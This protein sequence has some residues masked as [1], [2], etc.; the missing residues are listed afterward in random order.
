MKAARFEA[1]G[2]VDVALGDIRSQLQELVVR[3]LSQELMGGLDLDALAELRVHAGPPDVLSLPQ[4]LEVQLFEP[5]VLD[6]FFAQTAAGFDSEV[7]D[8]AG[9][10][11]L[12]EDVDDAVGVDLEGDLDLHLA[13]RGR[14]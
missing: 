2:G 12:G 14:A 13:A 8:V 6:L 11:V 10:L 1:V 5:Q 3:E 7:L 9:L 4:R